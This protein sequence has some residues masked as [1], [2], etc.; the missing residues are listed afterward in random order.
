MPGDTLFLLNE[1]CEW[2][3]GS[4]GEPAGFRMGLLLPHRGERFAG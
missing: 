2:E 4:G 1:A 3:T